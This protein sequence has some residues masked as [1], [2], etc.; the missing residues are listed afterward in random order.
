M[1]MTQ[2]RV[3]GRCD[4][5]AHARNAT[6]DEPPPSRRRAGEASNTAGWES[7][8]NR[9]V[10]AR[11][12]RELTAGFVA[13]L[14]SNPDE[15]TMAAIKTAAETTALAEWRA[16]PPCAVPRPT[17]LPHS[18]G[19]KARPI[20]RRAD[21]VAM[22][23]QTIW[24]IVGRISRREPRRI[25]GGCA[26][27]RDMKRARAIPIDAALADKALL[28]AA[29]G[30]LASWRT[31]VATFKA[32][33]GRPLT[34]DERE[35]FD[36]VAGGRKPPM[37]KVKE[38]IAVVSR[39][40]GKG[41]A[42]AAMATYE[43]ALVDHVAVLAPGEVGVIAIVNSDK[44][45]GWNCPGVYTRLFRGVADLARPDFRGDRGRN[46]LAQWDRNLHAGIGFQDAEGPNVAFRNP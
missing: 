22:Q 5:S 43:A 32:A 24:S 3:V 42:G 36:R 46:P 8:D 10:L 30:D 23:A 2:F 33:Y 6:T 20:A 35:A 28:G 26:G 31:W 18:C 25:V 14:G 19:F 15:L 27:R 40:G 4:S 12:V 45:P 44:K 21:L 13:A 16:A 7:I 37:R 11:R 29:L 1:A 39:R 41:R 17:P 9:T 34:A 38:L